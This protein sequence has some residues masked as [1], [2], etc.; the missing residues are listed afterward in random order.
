MKLSGLF[1][2]SMVASALALVGCGGDI[3]ITPTTIDNSVDNSVTTGGGSTQENPC[4][5]YVVDG[6][7]FQGEVSGANC[8]YKQSFASNAKE[9]ESGL[10]IPELKDGV[11]IFEGSLFI[12]KDVDTSN[13]GVIDPDGPTLTIEAGAT[14]AFTK[15][16]SF[17]R[18]A[19]GAK[20]QAEGTV[21][22]P[23]VFTS[24][25]EVDGDAATV[26]GISDWGGVQVNG[27]AT[28]NKCSAV[29]AQNGICNREAEGIV[30]Y[31]GG[32]DDN[33]DSGTLKHVVIK[34]AG[35]GVEGD[36]L[37]GLT[38]NAVGAGTLI[39]YV[40]VHA[41]FDDGIEL[42]G[43][44]VDLKHIVVTETGDD[45]ID[46]D[47]G[48]KGRAQY[49]L[50]TSKVRGNHGLETDGAGATPTGDEATTV[51]NP[52]VSNV[53]VVSTGTVG[54]DGRKEGAGFEM[55][56]WGKVNFANA[57]FVNSD[58]QDNTGCLDLR[59]KEDAGQ[60]AGVIANAQAGD[61]KFNSVIFACGTNFETLDVAVA[62]FDMADWFANATGNSNNLTL[63]FADFSNV[64]AADGV[65]TKATLTDKDGVAATV[66]PYDMK[67][68]DSFFETTDFVGAVKEGDTSEWAQFVQKSVARAAN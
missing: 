27:L 35:Y 43:G 60:A 4:A 51:S 39:D 34:Y 30:S 44:K 3:N 33:D 67:A 36:E 50:V 11:H 18:I 17:V 65:S 16:D 52:H 15:P 9:I 28:N 5:K 7:E 22:K 19:R 20:I 62:G 49:V 8:L 41:G 59:N 66:T 45:G 55:K 21:D 53:T 68:V 56:E 48:W 26:P 32:N 63:G 10:L 42:F 23:V 40:H 47:Q 25:K 58:A 2:V 46:W 37:N 24:I 64:L 14:I 31:F 61:I 6:A 13:G 1:K 57:L 54:E 38:L 29:N 12:G